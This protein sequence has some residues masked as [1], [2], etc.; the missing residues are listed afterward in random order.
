MGNARQYDSFDK[1]IRRAIEKEEEIRYQTRKTLERRDAAPARLRKHFVESRDPSGRLCYRATLTDG[2]WQALKQ[3]EGALQEAGLKM[4]TE[5]DGGEKYADEV[6][7]IGSVLEIIHQALVAHSITLENYQ[8][9]DEAAVAMERWH[10]HGTQTDDRQ[11]PQS[12]KKGRSVEEV[13]VS[14]KKLPP[15][16]IVFGCLIVA[17]LFTKLF[18]IRI[19]VSDRKVQT[20]IARDNL[21]SEHVSAFKGL[22]WR[23]LFLLSGVLLIVSIL[24]V[25]FVGTVIICAIV[26]NEAVGVGDILISIG[27]LVV[28]IIILRF[29][30]SARYKLERQL[31]ASRKES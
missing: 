11:R 31:Y 14:L 18:G 20:Q 23:I 2:Q 5:K 13:F 25:I 10:K 30:N 19:A 7:Y 24:G 3:M 27:C 22:I 21:K 15:I 12:T 17:G 16:A 4:M 8:K 9:L 28:S 29:V 26:D 1:A 6:T